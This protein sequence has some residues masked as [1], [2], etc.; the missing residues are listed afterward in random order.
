MTI[1]WLASSGI[2]WGYRIALTVDRYMKADCDNFV[3]M[4]HIGA[5]SG[6][7]NRNTQ[8]VFHRLDPDSSGSYTNR[9]KIAFALQD[10]PQ[11]ELYAEIEE[12]DEVREEATIWVKIGSIVAGDSSNLILYMYYDP[13]MSD[14]TTY[15][16]DFGDQSDVG[17]KVFNSSGTIQLHHD[18]VYHLSDQLDDSPDLIKYSGRHGATDYK[19]TTQVMGD[20]SNPIV[21]R[22]ARALNFDGSEEFCYKTY[23]TNGTSRFAANPFNVMLSAWVRT[24]NAAD[25]MVAI[26]IGYW[27]D[28]GFNKQSLGIGVRGGNA[29]IWARNAALETV[30]SGAAVADGSWHHII[31]YADAATFD[32]YLYVDGVLS[33]SGGLWN[34]INDGRVCIGRE[35]WEDDDHFDGDLDECRVYGT[36]AANVATEIK[37]GLYED[38]YKNEADEFFSFSVE[39]QLSSTDLNFCSLG[40]KH[41]TQ[42]LFLAR[43]YGSS[44]DYLKFMLKSVST[45]TTDLNF[46]VEGATVDDLLFLA[47]GKTCNELGFVV[48][49]SIQSIKKGHAR[50][51][52]VSSYFDPIY[53]FLEDEITDF[54]VRGEVPI[55][56]VTIRYMYDY[57]S[58]QFG[59]SLTKHN[60]SSKSIYGNT[61]EYKKVYEMKWIQDGRTANV[62][63]DAILNT[64]SLPELYCTF[65][66]NLSSLY[67]EEN[68]PV[69]IT[70]EAGLDENGWVQ[71][72]CWIVKK[73]RSGVVIKYEVVMKHT[74]YGLLHTELVRLV[75]AT[76]LG[77]AGGVTVTYESG[78]ATITVYADVEGSP[79]ISG[80]NVTISG[81]VKIT[82]EKGQVY[83][84]LDPG[85]YTAYLVASGYEDTS[86][87]FDV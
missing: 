50:S 34:A 37:A 74:Q 35:V 15:I 8:C 28:P 65:S 52:S 77:E 61:G 40:G 69:T 32:Y 11:T 6:T 71:A 45:L 87:T 67:L 85:E 5:S 60:L 10:A 57:S 55:N 76:G 48:G 20:S 47:E 46:L 23:L 26:A 18:L 41:Y 81:T 27:Q 30:I 49:E 70:H 68:D 39:H 73:S 80:V 62:I 59:A 51:S 75:L 42:L 53:H 2:H 72:P 66:H 9:L 7:N 64:V 54:E 44:H 3:A 17:T 79:P 16:F 83:F 43:G 86:I 19:L 29:C 24:S 12:W 36:L 56:E 13:D 78:V 14:N 4:V 1:D 22:V 84:P 82:N 33:N 31:G 38:I 25:D 63:A 21:G 58:N